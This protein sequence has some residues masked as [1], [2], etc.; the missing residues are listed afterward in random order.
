MNRNM[1]CWQVVLV[2]I[3]ATWIGTSSPQELLPSEESAT[4]FQVNLDQVTHAGGC[5]LPF[6]LPCPQIGVPEDDICNCTG[7]D[8]IN[9]CAPAEAV[10]AVEPDWFKLFAG[11]LDDYTGNG[12]NQFGYGSTIDATNLCAIIY[13][14]EPTCEQLLFSQRWTCNQAEVFRNE[15]PS[16]QGNPADIVWCDTHVAQQ[17][18]ETPL[19]SQFARVN[20]IG[21]QLFSGK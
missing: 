1:L 20:G 11:W 15:E 5:L 19:Q 17:T 18:R 9:S 7:A 16:Y 13:T 12:W 10:A 8:D 2:L 6:T 4:P 14:C 21:L 3:V